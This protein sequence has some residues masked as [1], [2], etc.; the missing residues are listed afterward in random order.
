MGVAHVLEGSVRRAG[1]RI[2]INAQL[3]AT[4]NGGSVWAER[5]DRDFNDI[6]AVQDDI[7][8]EITKA[9]QANLQGDAIASRGGSADAYE[10]CLRARTSTSNQSER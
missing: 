1:G 8:L 4:E 7:T 3:V 5:Y 9:L 6:F 10:L 2:R